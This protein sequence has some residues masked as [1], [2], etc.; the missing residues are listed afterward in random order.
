VPCNSH[1]G[2]DTV[3]TEPLF[4][5]N[6]L[7][8][9]CEMQGRTKGWAFVDNKGEQAP[10]NHFSEAILDWLV[11]IQEAYP[12]L[13]NPGINVYEEVGLARSFRRGRVRDGLPKTLASKRGKWARKG[14][15]ML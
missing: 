4:W 11:R 9:E 10:M 12:G 8:E 15:G 13:I 3:R 14:L 5:I 1:G 7:I 2:G 6:R